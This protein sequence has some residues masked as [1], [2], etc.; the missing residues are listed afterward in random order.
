MSARLTDLVREIYD[1]TVLA[2]RV[3]A[4]TGGTYAIAALVITDGG[5]GYDDTFAVTFS[6]GGG[7]GAAGTATAVG[8]VIQDVEITNPGTGYT[9]A[10]TPDFT[11]G[12]GSD[13]DGDAILAAETL[14]AIPTVDIEAGTLDLRLILSSVAYIY[15]LVAGTDAESSPTVIRPDD[16][17]GTTNEKVWKRTPISNDPDALHVNVAAEINGITAKT[18]PVSADLMLI[19]D[20]AASNAKK[21]ITVGS[22]IPTGVIW[23]WS[24]TIATIPSGWALCDGSN[25][26]PDLRDRFVVGA[27]SDDSGAAKTNLTGA[28]TVSGGS[29]SHTHTASVLDASLTA[30]PTGDVQDNTGAGAW[31]PSFDPEVTVDSTS[32]PQPYYA[33][34]LIMRL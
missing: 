14:D 27:T 30:N 18:T 31:D 29:I 15:R 17:A 22:L 4:L 32:A 13:G 16:Y 2:K 7:S 9:S 5:T 10:P 20:S 6:G 34:A 1:R 3:A 24:G 19:E 23:M 25:G 11:A 12:S 26:T 28:L 21:K 33:L 8:G